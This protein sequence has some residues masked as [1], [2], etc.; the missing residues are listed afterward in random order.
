MLRSWQEGT[1]GTAWLPTALHCLWKKA[2]HQRKIASGLLLG[3]KTCSAAASRK[4]TL[5]ANR[6]LSLSWYYD[7]LSPFDQSS[8]TPHTILAFALAPVVW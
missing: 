6:S 7:V 8:K 3:I 5:T 1:R 4:R 2:E